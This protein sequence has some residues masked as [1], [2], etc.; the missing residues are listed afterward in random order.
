MFW[1]VFPLKWPNTDTNTEAATA[2]YQIKNIKTTFIK[3]EI[4]TYLHY[5]EC[6]FLQ[7]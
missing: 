6:K 7:I 3:S 5:N 1:T 4:K 2:N